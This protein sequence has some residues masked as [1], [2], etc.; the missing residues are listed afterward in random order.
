MK[1]SEQQ[2]LNKIIGKYYHLYGFNYQKLYVNCMEMLNK[3]S[4][5]L[6]IHLWDEKKKKFGNY[7]FTIQNYNAFRDL[8]IVDDSYFHQRKFIE[9]WDGGRASYTPLY[10]DG[11]YTLPRF[12]GITKEDILNCT[13]HFIKKILD[14]YWIWNIYFADK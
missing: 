10:L 6:D 9:T 3:D 14:N 5:S 4:C 11:I 1:P 2:K 7:L 12:I 13:K 8:D